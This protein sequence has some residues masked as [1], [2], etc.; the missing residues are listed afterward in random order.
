MCRATAAPPV[1][2]GISSENVSGW[3][4][5]RK[6]LAAARL[7]VPRLP[8]QMRAQF[9]QLISGRNGE[10]CVAVLAV[11]GAAHV[12]G[13]A[14]IADLVLLLGGGILLGAQAIEVAKDLGRAVTLASGATSEKDLEA[15]ADRLA[16]VVVA[17]GVALLA[18]LVLKGGRKLGG[19]TAAAVEGAEGAILARWNAVI[20]QL[21]L[22]V[23]P[24]KGAL[25][26]RVGRG[27]A[28]IAAR[29]EGRT[30]LEML[31]EK[32][33]NQHFERLYQAEFGT[34]QST[35]TGSIWEAV[36]RKYAAGLQ[37]EIEAYVDA[38]S[39][40]LSK[41]VRGVGPAGW[42]AQIWAEL[43][44][45]TDVVLHNQQITSVRVY[46]LSGGNLE[47]ISH[48]TREQIQKALAASH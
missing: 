44:E 45:I 14:E 40:R 7:T 32:P 8:V 36:S 18:A 12:F 3:S 15:C 34:V 37:G 38:P 10:I 16:R 23:A 43:D 22:T 46:N 17:V 25:W 19:R 30:T 26:S 33:Q 29:A 21:D 2:L 5:Q 4:A 20:E 1:V 35:T 24:N 28:G 47:L 13:V 42:R 11:W 31:L 48:L 6:L 41:D 27:S 39:L 9:A